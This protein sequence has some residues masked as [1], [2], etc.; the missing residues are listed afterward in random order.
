MRY[1]TSV[2]DIGDLQAALKEALEVKKDRFAY[3]QLGK[4]KTLLMIFF[5]SSLRTRLSTQKAAMNLG[6]NVMVLDVNQGAWKLETERGVIMDGDNKTIPHFLSTINDVYNSGE[7]AIQARRTGENYGSNIALLDCIS[8]DINNGIFRKGHN[9]IHLPAA[10]S[11]SGMA[12]DACWFAK[13]VSKLHSAGEDKELEALLLQENIY[14]KYIDSLP[15]YD[16]KTTKTEAIT[17]QRKRWIAV[18]YAILKSV[19]KDFPKA[20]YKGNIAYCD[21]IIQW[22]LP[23][24]LIQLAA[25]I[26]CTLI[27]LLLNPMDMGIKWF[28][29]FICQICALTIPIP[30]KY[31]NKELFITLICKMPILIILTLKKMFHLKNAHK[32]FIHTEHGNK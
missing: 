10:L 19:I 18:Q 31:Y 24:R 3:Q 13:N 16:E 8:E 20:L 15:V 2:K 29:L 17:N 25:I 22:L 12:F 1:F 6:M 5:N 11:G 4:N 28:L 9:A 27:T 26:M 23:P 30:I 14:I 32:N 7:R 21:K